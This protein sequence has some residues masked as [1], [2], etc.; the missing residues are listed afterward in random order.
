[1]TTVQRDL[2]NYIMVITFHVN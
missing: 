1:M 2:A